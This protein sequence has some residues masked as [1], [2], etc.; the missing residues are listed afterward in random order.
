MAEGLHL[1]RGGCVVPKNVKH[2]RVDPSV[3]AIKD[4]AFWI[5]GSS[6]IEDRDSQR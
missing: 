1:H 4:K 2:V 6:A 3:R 5:L